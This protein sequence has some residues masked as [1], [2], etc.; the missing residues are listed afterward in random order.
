MLFFVLNFVFS[1][2]YSGLNSLYVIV[3]SSYH[4]AGLLSLGAL[5]PNRFTT[6]ENLFWDAVQIVIVSR[7]CDNGGT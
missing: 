3:L 6:W 1:T 2:I 7:N 5:F 4:I